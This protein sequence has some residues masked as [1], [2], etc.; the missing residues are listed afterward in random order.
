[1]RV[2]GF[3][4]NVVDK[5]IHK[6]TIYP[7][8]NCVNFAV[9]AKKLGAESAY[10]GVFGSDDSADHIIHTLKELGI[11]LSYCKQYEGENGCTE[12]DLKDGDRVLVGWN[13]GGIAN[14]K[15]IVISQKEIEY[16][17]GFQHIHS[18]CY[19]KSETELV[20]LRSLDALVSFDF[21]EEQTFRKD[22]F[23]KWVCPNIDFALFSGSGCSIE[24]IKNLIQ[25][26]VDYGTPYVLVTRGS[27]GAIF[28][29]G[30]TFYEGKPKIVEPI[31]TMGCGDAFVTAFIIYLLRNGWSKTNRP[32]P[33]TIQNGL[34]VAAEFSAENCFVEGAF[35]YG[36][37][38]INV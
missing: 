12:V 2:I 20:K 13:E 24:E 32:S 23:L 30:Q 34:R 18:S 15:P 26:T 9:Y 6:E 29:D 10:M 36:K 28:F 4:D 37:K 11:D 7:G 35:G 19:S 22:D 3:G 5:Y 17:K 8:G 14:E 31:D 27:Q 21:S 33:E 25:R 38:Y 1:M 16:L